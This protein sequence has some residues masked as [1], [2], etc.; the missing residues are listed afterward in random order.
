MTKLLKGA[1]VALLLAISPVYAEVSIPQS[2]RV[3]NKS[4]GVCS[5]CAIEMTGRYNGDKR[6]YGLV[7]ARVKLN[8][9]N[10]GTNGG[11]PSRIKDQLKELGVTDYIFQEPSDAKD[12]T[13]LKNND[14]NKQP[15]VVNVRNY[16]KE[17]QYHSI[18]LTDFNDTTVTFID[19]N[20]ADKS[21]VAVMRW[22]D[23]HW[24]GSALIIHPP[25]P[26]ETVVVDKKPEPKEQPSV[27]SKQP[28]TTP[29]PS[30]ELPPMVVTLM[31]TGMSQKDAELTIQRMLTVPGNK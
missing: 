5:W 17:G 1:I 20:V 27:T 19:P 10:P 2:C 3:P 4:V 9:Q 31:K 11:T 21:M 8:E 16:P 26:T 7:E 23:Q 6:L 12:K 18:L 30:S 22:F 24:D 15:V 25:K 29:V 13:I 14:W 28:E